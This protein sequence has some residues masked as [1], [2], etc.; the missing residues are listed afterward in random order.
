MKK[1]FFS[2]FLG[3]LLTSAISAA[4]ADDI[5]PAC[6]VTDFTTQEPININDY[7]GKVIYL[8]FWASWCP[9]CKQS[10]PALN[11]LH[12]EFK[13]RGFEV[14]AINLDEEKK[15]ASQFLQANPVDFTIAYDAQRICPKAYE[16]MA[17]PS[18]YIIDKQG[19]IREV[20]LG[21]KENDVTEIQN[22]ILTLL[23]E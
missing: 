9:P 6:N 3:I 7:K 17:M 10:F 11:K 15:D 1:Q 13:K 16:V 14:V 19:V 20:H 5:A 2:L 22:M 8:D 23:A 4:E 12:N 21:F 18:S